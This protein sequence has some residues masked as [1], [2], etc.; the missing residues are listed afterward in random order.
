[1]IYSLE[2]SRQIA[3]EFTQQL[4]PFYY[5][6]FSY[7]PEKYIWIDTKEF[8]E[9]T[10]V[11][12]LPEKVVVE[13]LLELY[14][15]DPERVD[16]LLK[17]PKEHKDS[18][19]IIFISSPYDIFI[20][21]EKASENDTSIS[22]KVAE[23]QKD[24]ES[25]LLAYRSGLVQEAL[26]RKDQGEELTFALIDSVPVLMPQEEALATYISTMGEPAKLDWV[27]LMERGGLMFLYVETKTDTIWFN[28]V[29]Q[30]F[31]NELRK[32]L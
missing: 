32:K 22:Q 23:I 26:F 25:Y 2:E 17:E 1:M 24:A 31:E 21:I 10:A 9:Y 28:T 20:F 14:D 27:E 15:K 3:K 8:P 19:T 6:F 5:Q 16:A 30:R 11:E 4:L 7:N 18:I 29:D 13:R 12:L